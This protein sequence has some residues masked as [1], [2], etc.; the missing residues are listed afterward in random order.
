MTFWLGYRKGSFWLKEQA[1]CV[2][3]ATLRAQQ[4]MPLVGAVE[5]WD[6][7]GLHRMPDYLTCAIEIDRITARLNF[8][9]KPAT[10]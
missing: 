5:I 7:N 4:L 1:A 3:S 2:R 9:S 10:P 8:D 6:S